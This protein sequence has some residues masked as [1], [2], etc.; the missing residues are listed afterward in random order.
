MSLNKKAQNQTLLNAASLIIGI[1]IMMPFMYHAAYGVTYS[2]AA[3]VAQDLGMTINIMQS[4]P[5]P[6]QVQ[7]RL[8]TSD[9]IISLTE[10]Y[11]SVKGANNEF[12][13]P[14][15]QPQYASIR[16]STAEYEP[17]LSLTSSDDKVGLE[18]DQAGLAT[19]CEAIDNQ[20][21][22]LEVFLDAT[23]DNADLERQINASLENSEAVTVVDQPSE[24]S[25]TVQ[26]TTTQSKDVLVRHS[27]DDTSLTTETGCHITTNIEASETVFTTYNLRL[28]ESLS[29]RTVVVELGGDADFNINSVAGA[30]AAGITKTTNE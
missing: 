7:Y 4:V 24:E 11:V 25:V 18:G 29:Q 1:T 9:Y 27:R 15:Y 13:N 22:R 2:N 20:K 21:E 12:Q 8:D 28:D 17:T 6:T 3:V 14:L 16:P 30:I 19:F 26:V 23:L 10:Q 5:A